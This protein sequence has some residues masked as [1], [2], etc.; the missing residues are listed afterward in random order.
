MMS[1]EKSKPRQQIDLLRKSISN[2]K[3]NEKIIL[4]LYPYYYKNPVLAGNWLDRQR[5]TNLA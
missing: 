3:D 2:L 1:R 4:G 5:A